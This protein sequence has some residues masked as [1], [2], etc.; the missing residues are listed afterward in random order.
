M[1]NTHS[2]TEEVQLKGHIIDSLLLPRAFE[3]I[4]DL[5]GEFE[6]LTIYVGKRKDETSLA[7]M[8][9]TAPSPTVLSEIL[10]QLQELGAELMGAEDVETEPAPRDGAL[11]ADFYS[12]T[13]LPS[14]VRLG[15][16]WVAVEGTEMDLAIVVDREAGRAST[17]PMIQVRKGEPVAVGHAGI[18]VLP[19]ERARGGEIFS[20]MN[21]A[22][23]S[24]KPKKL[25]IREVAR[26]M[27]AIHQRGGK[28]LVVAGPAIIHSPARRQDPHGGRPGHRAQR[29][30]AVSRLP[31]ARRVRRCAVRRQ[32][33]RRA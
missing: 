10:D 23:S 15:G 21:S 20:F 19:L 22:V 8:R 1:N 17:R 30:G 24:E 29:G 27:H 33:H 28:I 7:K 18:R 11:P 14:E 13:N 31:G 9:V 2:L 3:L 32:R 12:T 6:I 25:V 5:G 26:E 4:M 16:E